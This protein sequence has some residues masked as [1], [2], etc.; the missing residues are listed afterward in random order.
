MHY[1][2]A[3]NKVMARSLKR[4]AIIQKTRLR[5]NYSKKSLTYMYIDKGV[6]YVCRDKFC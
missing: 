6:L 1:S 3:W 4:S 2:K 5:I